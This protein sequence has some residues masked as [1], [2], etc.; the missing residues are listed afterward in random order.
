MKALTVYD[1]YLELEAAIDNGY[2]DKTILVATD[3]EGNDYR[4]IYYGLTTNP[5]TVK[6]C[7]ENS[8]CTIK[9]NNKNIILG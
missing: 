3:D 5:E 2:K 6:E 1:L 8:C 4:H 9:P 7:I